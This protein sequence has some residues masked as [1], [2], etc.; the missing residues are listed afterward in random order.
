MKVPEVIQV[1]QMLN[2]LTACIAEYV[3]ERQE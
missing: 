1:T 3:D 2:L